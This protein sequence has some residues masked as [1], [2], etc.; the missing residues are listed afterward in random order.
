M[1]KDS[2]KEVDSFFQVYGSLDYPLLLVD[3]RGEILSA[4]DEA[5]RL[6]PFFQSQNANLTDFLDS[7]PD[8]IPFWLEDFQTQKPLRLLSTLGL[9]YHGLR[10]KSTPLRRE[11]EG[12]SLWL[13]QLNPPSW[14]PLAHGF[15]RE[16]MLRIASVPVQELLKEIHPLTQE[17]AQGSPILNDLLDMAAGFIHAHK[18]L[19]LWRGPDRRLG[20]GAHT[21]FTPEE[22]QAVLQ[23]FKHEPKALDAD[24]FKEAAE[25][26]LVYRFQR[27]REPLFALDDGLT[28]AGISWETAWIDGI[29]GFGAVL[30]L[31]PNDP[32]DTFRHDATEIFIKIGR[33]AENAITTQSLSQTYDVLKQAQKRMQDAGKMAALGEMAAGMA[34]EL[35]QPITALANFLSNI[36]DHIE[37]G[38]FTKLKENLSEYRE[39]SQRNLDRLMGIVNHLRTYSR[40]DEFR[41]SPVSMV[42]WF[43]GIRETYL[44]SQLETRGISLLVQIPETL[45]L[46]EIDPQRME[47]V[48]LNLFSN[49]MDAVEGQDTPS[50][51]LDME[52]KENTLIIRVTDNGTGFPPEILQR[53]VLPFFSTKS[54]EKGTGLGLAISQAIVESHQGELNIRNHPQK[55][56]QIEVVLPL[57][58]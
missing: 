32:G 30:T 39:R 34:H 24:V 52:I 8:S 46:V 16:L 4:S 35:R 42:E 41:F 40:A 12:K 22:I 17:N 15:Q 57:Q 56:G 21:G 18:I 7:P 3:E 44:T 38:R 50:I 1:A 19:L 43:Q 14:Q 25:A 6:F 27:N 20:L 31:F 47:Q 9:P 45:P 10:V 58:K 11:P 29:G 49:A 51:F 33:L 53:G 54:A 13:L 55:G 36:L 48:M 2:P 5:V 28:R 23:W 37:A 26:G